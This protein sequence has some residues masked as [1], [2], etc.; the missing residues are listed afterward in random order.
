M[1]RQWGRPRKVEIIISCV[2]N[3]HIPRIIRRAGFI[4]N[5]ETDYY[6]LDVIISVG[7]RLKYVRG[8]QFRQWANKVLKEYMLKGY[9]VNQRFLEMENRI[10]NR[11]HRQQS[12]IDNL[13]DKVDFII[14]SSIKPKEGI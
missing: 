1:P 4:Q 8:T 3:L 13:S 12:Q 6:S 5:I 11:F 14:S 2:Q 10:D 7:Y 9:S